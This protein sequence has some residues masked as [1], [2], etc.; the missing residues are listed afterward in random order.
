MI[1]NGYS[2][3]ISGG[4]AGVIARASTTITDAGTITGAGGTA[5][6]FSSGDDLLVVDQG[7]VFNGSVLGDGG[8]D[9]VQFTAPGAH[10]ITGFSGFEDYELPDGG[11]N[12]LTLAAANFTG[13]TNST[14]A[15]TDG[16]SGNTIDASAVHD[17]VLAYDLNNPAG[18]HVAITFPYWP[19][20][21]EVRSPVIES[22]PEDC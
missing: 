15:V 16:N 3:L 5:V 18:P 7:A 6:A 14:I 21:A 11:A 19:E 13:V 2:D 10:D 12:S 9:Q 22:A 1:T 8:T 17:G 20:R 4:I